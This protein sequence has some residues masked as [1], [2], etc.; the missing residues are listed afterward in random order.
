M[1][2]ELDV[3]KLHDS[4][5]VYELTI[6]ILEIMQTSNLQFVWHSILF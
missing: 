1:F 2:L 5:G 4:H 6:D 3:W